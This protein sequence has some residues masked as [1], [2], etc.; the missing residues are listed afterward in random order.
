MQPEG[1]QEAIHAGDKAVAPGHADREDVRQQHQPEEDQQ[2]QHQQ[3]VADEH[4][5]GWGLPLR[6]DELHDRR[7]SGGVRGGG[8]SGGLRL[9]QEIIRAH[10]EQVRQDDNVGRVR[11]RAVGLP[12]GQAL[13]G[14]ADLRG[15][16]LLGEAPG[17]AQ[18]LQL[19][20]KGHGATSF[21][22]SGPI[23]AR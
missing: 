16:L 4:R 19:F 2:P 11:Q 9:P 15:Q 1:Q 3:D 20:T 17:L 22:F 8:G 12:F 23:I 7:R 13:S 5:S 21:V 10:A 14:H 6:L 18:F